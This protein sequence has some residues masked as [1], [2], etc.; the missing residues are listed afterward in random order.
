MGWLIDP[1]EQMVFVHIAQQ[2]T[3]CLEHTGDFI[4]MPS[5]SQEL[6]LTICQIFDWLQVN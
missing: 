3:Q 6:Q 1:S 5:F 2:P 4:P